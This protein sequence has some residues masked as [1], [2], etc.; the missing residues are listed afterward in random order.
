MERSAATLVPVRQSLQILAAS[1]MEVVG[2]LQST[3]ALLG[4]L[5]FPGLRSGDVSTSDTP[6]DGMSSALLPAEAAIFDRLTKLVEVMRKGVRVELNTIMNLYYSMDLEPLFAL[7][8]G[9]V[10]RSFQVVSAEVLRDALNAF[11]ETGEREKREDLEL[12]QNVGAEVDTVVEVPQA[13][14]TGDGGVGGQG[15]RQKLQE[16]ALMRAVDFGSLEAVEILV[17]SGAG[18]EVRREGGEGEGGKRALH[19]ACRDG[20]PEIAEF[21]V[22]S[23][24]EIEAATDI[25]VTPL[26]YAAQAGLTGLVRFLLGKSADVHAKTTDKGKTPIFNA[27]A[28]GHRDVVELLLNHGAKVNE[29]TNDEQCPLHFTCIRYNSIPRDHRS[30]AELLISRGADV[31]ARCRSGSSA[32][33]FAAWSGA[34][35][36]AE[37]L[38]ENGADRHARDNSGNTVC[39]AP[40]FA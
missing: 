21:L 29:R 30:I 39:S 13:A 16:T 36:V 28:D 11:M 31:D 15:I 32:L 20:K 27:V 22:C 33:H 8:I 9:N 7:D 25:G 2:M 3:D 34:L 12:L 6:Q 40:R 4:N 23:G 10:I 1:L 14:P 18:L 26:Y 5:N 17:G 35:G 19:F 38:L 24:A 37:V